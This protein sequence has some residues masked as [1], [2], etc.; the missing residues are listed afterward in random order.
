[1]NENG[2]RLLEL[3]SYHNL[4]ITNS[5]FQSKPHHKVSWRHPRSGHWHQLDLIITRRCDLRNVLQTRSF[6]SADCDTDHSLVCCKIKLQ[7]KNFHRARPKG[8]PRVDSSKA[9]DPT[10]A[11]AFLSALEESFP[12]LP[13][14]CSAQQYWDG[15]R[16]TIQRSALTVFGKR[17]RSSNDWFEANASVLTPIL[18]QKR[19]ALTNYKCTPNDKTL[20][21]LRSSRKILQQ[22]SRRCANSYWL[23]LCSN[24]QSAADSGNTKGMH[25]GIKKALG[26]THHTKICLRRIL[27]VTWKDMVTHTAI[28]ERAQLPSMYSLLRQ[29]R[30]R[31]LGHVCRMDDG[32]I[33]KDIL[34]AE[35][36]SGKR[37]KGR[38]QLRYKDVCKQ[39]L[40]SFNI[41]LDI[42]EVTAQDRLKWQKALRTGL[43]NYE[44]TL[45]KHHETKRI[46]RKQQQVS[47]S[48]FLSSGVAHTCDICGRVCPSR[49]GL[50]SHRRHCV[51]T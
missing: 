39:D 49:I 43:L 5:Y 46:K 28:L 24:I 16:D 6:H 37:Q 10:K 32:H 20:H 15:L 27:G 34:F 2:Q 31:W 38:P 18:E 22:T 44:N 7:V 29:R 51:K 13:Q 50:L 14:C 42:W 30:L 3:C 40:K 23:Q 9:A 45:A 11:A 21:A 33:S 19:I 1:M 26:P 48:P 35:L 41:S 36:S 4:C 8:P 25:D 17:L 47:S 12:R